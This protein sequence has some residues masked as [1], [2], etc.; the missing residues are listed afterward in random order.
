VI[1]E[2]PDRQVLVVGDTV[3][4]LVLTHLLRHAGYDPLLVS[5]TKTRPLSR[6][7]YLCLP[8]IRVF[9]AIGVGT[10]ARDF[11]TTADSV[12][13]CGSHSQGE[14]TVFSMENESEI[15]IPLVVS[16]ACLRRAL[17]TKLPEHQYG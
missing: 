2:R 6:V 5:G 1:T 9:E 17:E 3:V 15:R 14:S 12:S 13:V 8:V 4:G 10:S 16:T 11:G 7:A